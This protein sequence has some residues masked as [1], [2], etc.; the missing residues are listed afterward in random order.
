M[1]R[2]RER[3]H[4]IEHTLLCQRIDDLERVV[5]QDK[6]VEREL[7][8]LNSELEHYVATL[9]LQL[10]EARLGLQGA[11]SRTTPGSGTRSQVCGGGGAQSSMLVADTSNHPGIAREQQSKMNGNNG[12]NNSMQQDIA[13]LQQRITEL[14]EE[15]RR[16]TRYKDLFEHVPIAT[17]IYQ[18]DGTAIAANHQNEVLM[19]IPTDAVVENYNI[20]HDP[21]ANN[22]GYVAYFQQAA[23]GHIAIM[24]PTPFHTGETELTGRRD[25]RTVWIETAF[26]PIYD[27]QGT[28]A[29]IGETCIDV[30]DRI[31]AEQTLREQQT[32]LQGMID[33]SPSIIYAKDTDWRLILVNKQ[34]EALLQRDR[35]QIVGKTDYELFP[36]ESIDAIRANDRQVLESE[37]PATQEEYLILEDGRH[38]YLSIKFP[39]YDST[40]TCYGLGGITTDITAY[41]QMDDERTRL[42]EEIIRMQQS[43]LQELSTPLLPLSANV[44]LL[45][46]IGTIDSQ[47]AEQVMDTLLHGIAQNHAAVAILD[48]TG[49]QVVDTQVANALIQAMQAAR[50][51][52][53]Q[54]FITGIQPRI[55]Q[56]LI[57]LGVDLSSFVTHG[58]LQAGVAHAL[59]D[60]G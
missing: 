13:A 41:K 58:T 36:P 52:G 14:E 49:V 47:R 45:P 18:L 54:V 37:T 23:A 22:Q 28:I 33:N 8:R 21:A 7:R 27:T 11:Q 44:L 32:L 60:Q 19:N 59:K 5:H 25:D 26:F 50:L 29:Y 38:T 48:I 3:T 9:C 56:T 43:T 4:D 2:K 57:E 20:L 6:L 12:V 30:A 34:F 31:H 46:L 53:T 51:L 24:P 55:A 10:E 42:Q 40:G 35:E 15:N 1:R 16:L 17:L 39:L